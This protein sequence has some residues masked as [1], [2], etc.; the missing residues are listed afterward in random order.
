MVAFAEVDREWTMKTP[1]KNKR[2]RLAKYAVNEHVFY[3]RNAGCMHAVYGVH[4]RVH[5]SL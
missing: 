4:A 3:E 5:S 2:I 1:T